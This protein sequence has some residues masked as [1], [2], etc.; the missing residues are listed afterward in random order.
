[1]CLPNVVACIEGLSRSRREV[2][3]RTKRYNAVIKNLESCTS[4]WTIWDEM[5]FFAVRNDI[6]GGLKVMFE[7]YGHSYISRM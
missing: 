7:M 5:Y 3:M 6:K 2:E 1:M 4:D